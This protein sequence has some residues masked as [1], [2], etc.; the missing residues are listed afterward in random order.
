MIVDDVDPILINIWIDST[1]LMAT[2]GFVSYQWYDG[3]GIPISGATSEIFN[4]TSMGEYYVVV[5]DANGCS[6]SSYTIYYNINGL[7]NQEQ[8]IKIY[9]NPTS[10]L[11]T[12]D[13]TSDI[14]NITVL[15][16]IG[17]QLLQVENKSNQSSPIRLDLSS[18]AQGTYFIQIEQNNQILNYQIILQ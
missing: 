3:F 16:I 6:E 12:V 8:I 13:L 14:K 15:D 9:P 4:P 7:N 10:G 17:N 18:F 5:T 1:N 11:I 2:N